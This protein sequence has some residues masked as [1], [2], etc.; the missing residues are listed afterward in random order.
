MLYTDQSFTV[1]VWAKLNDT[2]TPR[3][4]LAQRGPSGVDPFTLRYD[5]S[6]W[7]AEMSN[8]A[9][10]PSKWWQAKGDAV[11]NK[12]THL[13]ATYNASART[14]TLTVGYQ[15]SPDTLK[16]AV[17][18]VIGWNST[19]VLSIGRGSTGESFN[20]DIDELTTLQGVRGS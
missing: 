20:G 11:A 16:N 17:A 19:G 5:G 1:D 8:A 10:N 9:V 2:G 14:L 6:R 13:V 3:T 4:V 7:S 12:W 15:D 18:C